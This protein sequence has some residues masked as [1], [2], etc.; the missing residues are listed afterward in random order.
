M[1]S[2]LSSVKTNLHLLSLNKQAQTGRANHEMGLMAC[3]ADVYKNEGV[4]GLWRGVGPTAQRAGVVVGKPRFFVIVYH[5]KVLSITLQWLISDYPSTTNT[6]L[7]LD[8]FLAHRRGT[9]S[10]RLH[11]ILLVA[12]PL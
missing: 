6:N 5:I 10:L 8:S 12:L 3:F 7:Y 1:K 4:K 2:L 9:S 11:E